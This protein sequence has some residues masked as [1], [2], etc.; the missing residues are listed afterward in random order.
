MGCILIRP[1]HQY[2]FTKCLKEKSTTCVCDGVSSCPEF[3][4]PNP[5]DS[6]AFKNYNDLVNKVP[7]TA[8]QKGQFGFYDQMIE[9]KPSI[10]RGISPDIEHYRSLIAGSGSDNDLINYAKSVSNEFKDYD[11]IYKKSLTSCGLE[12]NNI[13][14]RW[15]RIAARVGLFS[16]KK[17]TRDCHDNFEVVQYLV[18][19]LRHNN[20]VIERMIKALDA[21]QTVVMGVGSHCADP[22]RKSSHYVMIIDHFKHLDAPAFSFWDSDCGS[23]WTTLGDGFGI[24]FY[25]KGVLRTAFNDAD[26]TCS[27]CGTH[28][29]PCSR[30]RYIAIG[31]VATCELLGNCNIIK[32]GI[33]P[34]DSGF[35]SCEL[36]PDF[37]QNRSKK[38][39][40]LEGKE[41][42]NKN[43]K[44]ISSK[45]NPYCVIRKDCKK[46]SFNFNG[47]NPQANC[48]LG[49]CDD[50]NKVCCYDK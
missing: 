16:L 7:S 13:I 25:D 10:D 4:L 24:L 29:P 6:A 23:R 33:Q 19:D 40:E 38:H 20:E 36:E 30:T 22:F 49:A 39:N 3:I 45:L 18:E 17:G 11:K 26:D 32:R 37:Y 28:D 2:C 43:N 27:H 14:L 34:D 46:C 48:I 9:N 5:T 47:E 8:L 50:T 21:G 44:I 41:A 42:C 1:S 35:N 12:V 15:K 31:S